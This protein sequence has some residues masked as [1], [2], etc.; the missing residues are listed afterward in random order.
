MFEFLLQHQFWTAVV[1][2]WIFS[3]AVSSM[4][5]PGSKGSPVYLWFYRF[6]HTTAGNVATAFGSRIPGLKVL[7]PVLLIPLLLISTTA[8]AAHYTIH[9]GAVDKTDS[10]AYD[11]LLIAQKLIDQGRTDDEAGKLPADTKAAFNSLIQSYNVARESWLV[12]RGAITTNISAD[13]Y[14]TQLT[15]NVSDLIDAIR[16]LDPKTVKN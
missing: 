8:C 12:Y 9:P 6:C 16:N 14:L 5:D 13:V 1:L 4:P 10:A 15:R 2:Y 7:I 3:A 11:A